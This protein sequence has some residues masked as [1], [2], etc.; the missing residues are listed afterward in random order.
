MPR[1]EPALISEERRIFDSEGPASAAIVP[2]ASCPNKLCYS[3]KQKYE[4]RQYLR[5]YNTRGRSTPNIRKLNKGKMPPCKVSVITTKSTNVW[6]LF[7]EEQQ[8]H[9]V[10]LVKYL[11]STC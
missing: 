3:S 9:L 8:L 1:R 4:E 5:A 7:V 2:S 6:A 11:F 10:H